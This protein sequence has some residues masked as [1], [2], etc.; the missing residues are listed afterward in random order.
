MAEKTTLGLA[1]FYLATM[2]GIGDLAELGRG[3]YYWTGE[4]ITSTLSL[5][6]AVGAV[7]F[8]HWRQLLAKR[9]DL[10]E[11]GHSLIHFHLF[12]ASSLLVL[13]LVVHGKNSFSSLVEML[14]GEGGRTLA[15]AAV[16]L[17]ITA[18]LWV[19]H[20]RLLGQE[21]EYGKAAARR[22]R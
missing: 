9:G 4:E 10:S 20:V 2:V 16:N 18:G 21:I 7:W 13:G 8:W 5:A 12:M 22:K 15:A 6:A 11:D 1:V 17:A 14:Q 19:H 3:S